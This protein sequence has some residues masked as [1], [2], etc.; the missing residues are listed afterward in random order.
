MSKHQVKN[1]KVSAW[2][3]SPLAGEPPMLDAIL[4]DELACRLGEKHHKKMG[5]WTPKEEIKELPIP[6]TN[7]YINRKKVINC[8]APILPEPHAE[9]VDHI[10][11]RFNSSK[12][13]LLIAPKHRKSVMTASG[14]YKSKFDKI[15]VRLVDRVCWFIRGEREGINKL[16]K[17]IYAIGA[18]RG[19][20][21]GQIFEWTFEE[22]EDDYSIFCPCNGKIVLMR[23][24]P[25][26][27]RI[28][29]LCG[30][31]RSWGG[32]MPPYWHPAMQTE[33]LEPC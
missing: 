9:W 29:N 23:P 24:I 3:A 5:R 27:C 7:K 22:M 26:E 12:M 6:L 21:Y 18:H 1:Y 20:G 30:Y 13:A 31:R 14:P 2:L 19:I 33:I 28:D 15:R 16:L 17:S 32:G 11:K 10:A 4:G 25:V 8:S